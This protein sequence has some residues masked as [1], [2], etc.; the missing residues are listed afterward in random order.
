VSTTVLLADD[1]EIMRKA[2]VVLLQVDPN[3]Q[4][5]GQASSFA[6]TLELASKLRPQVIVLDLHMNNE[7]SVTP[8]Q[9][10]SGLMGS[11]LLA[12]SLWS[13][14]ETK[15]LAKAIGADVL[16]DKSNLAA[17]LIPAIKHHA[18]QS[19]EVIPGATESTERIRVPS[20]N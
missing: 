13:D 2:I 4:I 7:K 20:L 6:Q 17:E 5:L 14:D 8:A 16:L 11:Q 18:N 19:S 9:L 3:I 1:D 10:K 12:I 15:F